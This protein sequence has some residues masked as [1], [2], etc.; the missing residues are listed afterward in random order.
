MESSSSRRA[1]TLAAILEVEK[2]L[3][4]P[5]AGVLLASLAHAE[6]IPADPASVREWSEAIIVERDPSG[7]ERAVFAAPAALSVAT[8]DGGGAR[9][10]DALRAAAVAMIW[11]RESA[12]GAD[13]QPRYPRLRK[14]LVDHWDETRRSCDGPNK[15]LMFFDATLALDRAAEPRAGR[16]GFKTLSLPTMEAAKKE[17]R[18][19]TIGRPFEA[20]TDSGKFKKGGPSTPVDGPRPGPAEDRWATPQVSTIAQSSAPVPAPR[21]MEAAP[22]SMTPIIAGVVAVVVLGALAIVFLLR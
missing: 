20:I 12:L 4:P 2:V 19:G 9:H 1:T 3:A 22:R 5:R 16:E 18:V 17:V 13:G 10:V 15:L 8:Q 6:T 14:L 7:V 11:G 21:A